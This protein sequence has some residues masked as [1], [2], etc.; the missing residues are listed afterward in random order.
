MDGS[1]VFLTEKRRPDF[2]FGVHLQETALAAEVS[3]V[4]FLEV[5]PLLG[6]V[7]SGEDRRDRADWNAGAAVDALDGIDEELIVGFATGLVS[8]GVNAVYGAGVYTGAILGADTGF[9]DYIC[10]L[11]NLLG[12]TVSNLVMS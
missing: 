11:S 6:K 8:L 12:D 7:I 1:A 10:H 4:L 2:R 9:C 5:G 3:G